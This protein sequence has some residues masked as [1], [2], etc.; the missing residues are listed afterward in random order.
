MQGRELHEGPQADRSLSILKSVPQESLLTLL[1][2]R[3][4]QFEP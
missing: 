2:L 3:N 4:I 1:A